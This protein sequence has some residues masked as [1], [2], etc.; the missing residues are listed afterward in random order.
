MVLRSLRL[1]EG[2]KKDV[3]RGDTLVGIPDLTPKV[4]EHLSYVDGPWKG[5]GTESSEE[6]SRRNKDSF[7]RN[8]FGV[9][10]RSSSVHYTPFSNS[11]LF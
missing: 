3:P 1:L 9:L 4:F 6:K 11:I 5:R 2:T 8:K 10:C 7:P